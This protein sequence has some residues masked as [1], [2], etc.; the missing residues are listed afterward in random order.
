MAIRAFESDIRIIQDGKV[1]ARGTTAVNSPYIEASQKVV[2][3]YHDLLKSGF[4]IKYLDLGGGLGI[5]Y[6]PEQS[7]PYGP[8]ASHTA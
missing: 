2:E 1:V 5:K 4:D 8:C 6:K 3:L 7:R